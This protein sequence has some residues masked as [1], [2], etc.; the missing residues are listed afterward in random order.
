MKVESED[1]TVYPNPAKGI[2]YVKT[3]NREVR[4]LYN[5]VGQMLYRTYDNELDVSALS[6]GVYY[7]RCGNKVKKV[8]IECFM[9]IWDVMTINLKPRSERY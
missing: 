2:L 7:V 8:L 5:G 9:Y 4:E 6:S 1:L 3:K